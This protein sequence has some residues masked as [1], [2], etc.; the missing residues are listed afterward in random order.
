MVDNYQIHMFDL[1]AAALEVKSSLHL[2]ETTN[3]DEL[4]RY[5]LAVADYLY[6]TTNRPVRLHIERH[7]FAILDKKGFE[8]TDDLNLEVKAGLLTIEE[9]GNVTRL[10]CNDHVLLALSSEATTKVLDLNPELISVRTRS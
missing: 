10:R 6:A 7:D 2:T 4:R 5:G 8:F 1:A 9:L 3:Y